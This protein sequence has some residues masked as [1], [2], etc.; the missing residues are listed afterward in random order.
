MLSAKSIGVIEEKLIV[1]FDGIVKIELD[2]NLY[3]IILRL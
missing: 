1:T 2:D 3:R